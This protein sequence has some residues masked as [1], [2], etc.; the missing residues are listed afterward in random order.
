M[1]HDILKCDAIVRVQRAPDEPKRPP[2]LDLQR[3]LLLQRV[4]AMVLS[5]M[6]VAS[7]FA[8]AASR[9]MVGTFA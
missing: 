4:R 5:M 3:L 2:I 6:T 1:R 7:A 8:V 9:N